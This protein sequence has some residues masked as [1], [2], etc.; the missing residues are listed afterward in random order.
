MNRFEKW[1]LKR[2]LKK[3]VIQNFDHDVKIINLYKMIIDASRE[4]F[5]ED[6]LASLNATLENWHNEAL[7]SRPNCEIKYLS[8]INDYLC[9]I[10][11]LN[12]ELL[13]KD[14]ACMT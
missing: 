2:I 13:E 6:S 12:E 1:F 5:N 4:E 10:R 8:D 7:K 14:K 11:E 3:E 9:E